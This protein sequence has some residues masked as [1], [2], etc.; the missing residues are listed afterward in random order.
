MSTSWQL[1]VDIGSVHV[2]VVAV[3]P[4]GQRYSWVR[5]ARGRCL[6]VFC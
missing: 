4:E 3:T 5:P 2:K 6:G 1:G